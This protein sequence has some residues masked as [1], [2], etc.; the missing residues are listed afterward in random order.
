[1]SSEFLPESMYTIDSSISRQ[2]LSVGDVVTGKVMALNPHQKVLEINLGNGLIGFINV[3]DF[4]IYPIYK[5][6][7]SFSSTIYTFIRRNVRAKIISLEN[8]IITL[9]RKEHMLDTLSVL[10]EK[11]MFPNALI[12]GF[13]KLSAFVDIGEGITGRIYGKDF[14]NTLF[15]DAR[16]VGFKKGDIF[17]VK[18]LCFEESLNCFDLSRTQMLPTPKEVLKRNQVVDCTVFESVGDGIGYY[19]L[20]NKSICGILDSL[21]KLHYGETVKGI[22]KRISPKGP[23]LEFLAY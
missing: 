2:N 7:G 9:S 13:S 12:T 5:P 19:V 3:K 23:K 15:R 17:P 8:D 18:N 21:M 22:V 20:I 6:N 16:D 11:E 4:T 1:M 14:C 10:M